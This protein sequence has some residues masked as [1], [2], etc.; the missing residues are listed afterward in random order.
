MKEL[1]ERILK[2][3]RVMGDDALNV[4]K[5]LNQQID[6]VLMDKMAE[7]F[8]QHFKD[9]GITKVITV[10]SSGIAPA[11]MTG[12]KFQKPVVFA[13]KHKSITLNENFYSAEV[14]SFTSKKSNHIIMSRE[15]LTKDDNVLIID[16]FLANGQAVEGLMEIIDQADASLGGVGISIE[17]SFQKGR[18]MLDGLGV[19]VYS[20]ARIK[21]FKDGKIVF[22]PEVN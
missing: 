17:K 19:D 13:R 3:G 1:E 15:F 8:Y 2:D 18:K 7:E 6:P 4:D 22:Q 16:D 14:Y 11:V 21:E 9:K 10:E 20:L 5:F 12:Y